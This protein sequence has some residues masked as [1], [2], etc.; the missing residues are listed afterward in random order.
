[1]VRVP[2]KVAD[3]TLGS[4]SIR[5]VTGST[6]RGSRNACEPVRPGWQS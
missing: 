6:V 2:E 3:A 5:Y 4:I 1:M